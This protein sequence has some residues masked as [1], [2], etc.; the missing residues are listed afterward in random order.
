[1]ISKEKA[2]DL[3][4]QHIQKY[5]RLHETALMKDRTIEEDF[6]WV[7]F[8]NLKAFVEHGDRSAMLAGNAPLIY[9][10]DNERIVVTGTRLTIDT[11]VMLYKKYRDDMELFKKA[12]GEYVYGQDGW[13]NS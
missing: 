5:N 4:E 13:W 2:T 3:V 9:D 12:V 1:M 11:Y 8:Y 10:K 7:F 6:G